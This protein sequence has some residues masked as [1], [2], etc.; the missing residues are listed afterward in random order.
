MKQK[1]YVTM[2]LKASQALQQE[3][4]D[5]A[6]Q[7]GAVCVPRQGRT[8]AQ[9]QQAYGAQFLVYTSKG[10]QFAGPE[11]THYFS[12]NMAE[13]RIQHLRRGQRDHLL[14]AIGA[15]GPVRLLDCTCGF[16]ADAITASFGLPPGSVVDALEISPVL[17]AV[18]S[19]GCSHFVHAQDDVTAALRLIHCVRGDYRAYLRTMKDAAYDILYFDPMFSHPVLSSCQFQPVRAIQDHDALTAD[20]IRLAMQKAGRK[21]IVKGRSFRE[22]AQEFPQMKRYGGKYSRIG[23]AVWECDT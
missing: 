9:L 16:G 12:L 13:L 18:T 1:L 17:A 10:P 6:R 23:Y 14:E 3:G 20:D 5:W 2:S 21:V 11:G 7:I 19:W 4:A 22:L 8:V 15:A